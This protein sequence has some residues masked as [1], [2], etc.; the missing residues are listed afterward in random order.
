MRYGTRM[1]PHHARD[2]APRNLTRGLAFRSG[3]S[4]PLGIRDPC[5]DFNGEVDKCPWQKTLPNPDVIAT[6]SSSRGH[7]RR[8]PRTS[9]LHQVED[10]RDPE[11][12][13]GNEEIMVCRGLAE[14]HQIPRQL[15][16]IRPRSRALAIS[17]IKSKLFAFI[18]RCVCR[19][20]AEFPVGT[21]DVQIESRRG[22]PCT[23]LSEINLLRS[24]QG[25]QPLPEAPP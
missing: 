4:S 3:I 1:I 18:P 11:P 24:F 5:D 16:R 12:D 14:I 19:F 10:T 25:G 2:R 20:F 13:P 7:P 8:I 22:M 23:E 9:A 6:I 15:I 21:F 17:Q